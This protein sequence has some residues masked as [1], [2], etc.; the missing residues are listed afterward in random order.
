MLRPYL[1]P[2]TQP[3]IHREVCPRPQGDL[4][5]GPWVPAGPLPGPAAFASGVT[6]PEL[7]PG[8]GEAAGSH[9]GE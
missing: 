3:L 7:V 9:W 6:V 4:C 5:F 8:A 2:V 1:T